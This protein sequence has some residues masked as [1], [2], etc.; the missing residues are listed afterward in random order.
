MKYYLFIV[1]FFLFYT[2]GYSNNTIK[3]SNN[4]KTPQGL[5]VYH[6]GGRDIETITKYGVVLSGGRSS[7]YDAL[8]NMA[9]LAG[10]GDFLEINFNTPPGPWNKLYKRGKFNSVKSIV[11]KTKAHA[12]S[13][14]VYNIILN[15]EAVYFAG[16]DQWKYFKA[17]NGTRLVEA[18]NYIA[19]TKKVP[20]GGNSAGMAI[21]GEFLYS[22]EFRGEGVKS[23]QALNNPY[24]SKMTFREG[25][26][27]L[28]Y[29][30]SV[31]TDTHWSERNR[32]G[33]TITFIARLIQDKK[34][35]IKDIMAIAVDECTAV[36]IDE[37]GIARIFGDYP[38]YKD[39][40]FFIFPNSNPDRCI[41]GYTLD[42][43]SGVTI[44]KIEGDSRGSKSFDLK[45]RYSPD[46]LPYIVKVENGKLSENIQTPD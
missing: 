26:L 39:Y 12:N 45:S 34:A 22:A 20:I 46:I 27:S 23:A 24:N 38:K 32:L 41:D 17:W 33:R 40:A 14:F 8:D 21:L 3:I 6:L 4:V 35:N 43:T 31:I 5:K 42:W 37:T 18:V 9:E 30:N 29:M 10:G 25:F 19:K 16:G 36:V 11:I 15:S 44:Y 7:S 28:P 13:D 1:F 2:P